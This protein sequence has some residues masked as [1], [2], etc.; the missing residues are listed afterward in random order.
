MQEMKNDKSCCMTTSGV[1][2]RYCRYMHTKALQLPWILYVPCGS[3]IDIPT[4]PDTNKTQFPVVYSMFCY[5]QVC[6]LFLTCS[7]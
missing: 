3:F 7:T 2:S 6:T 4:H 5:M 1:P